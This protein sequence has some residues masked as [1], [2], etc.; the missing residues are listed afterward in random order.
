[1]PAK[2]VILKYLQTSNQEHSIGGISKHLGLKDSVVKMALKRMLDGKLIE[3]TG[4]GL[5]RYGV[6]IK[7][8]EQAMEEDKAPPCYHGIKL[9]ADVIPGFAKGMGFPVTSNTSNTESNEQS[10]TMQWDNLPERVR[11]DTM[12]TFLGAPNVPPLDVWVKSGNKL[13][14]KIDWRGRVITISI[15]SPT[16]EVEIASS[17]KPLLIP[18]VDC[19]LSAM[20]ILFYPIFHSIQWRFTWLGVC[21][22]MKH[23]DIRWNKKGELKSVTLSQ[24]GTV[25]GRWYDKQGLKVARRECHAELHATLPE[26]IANLEGQMP[27]AVE[28]MLAKV[29]D[30]VQKVREIGMAIDSRA[31]R[32]EGLYNRTL[33]EFDIVEVKERKL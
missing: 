25:I 4:R 22:D 33:K 14:H 2:D 31:K 28:D 11:T 32:I 10:N 18:E 30:E 13:I 20:E 26:L 6:Q 15:S 27:P 17:D 12:K 1:M 23:L 5:Y 7:A 3:K 29:R 9:I 24:M 8:I 21:Y 16:L 19:F